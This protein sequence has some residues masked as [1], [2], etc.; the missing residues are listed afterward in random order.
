MLDWI[1][2][3]HFQMHIQPYSVSRDNGQAA[4][5]DATILQTYAYLVD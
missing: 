3:W 4:F 5:Q 1:P 2:G